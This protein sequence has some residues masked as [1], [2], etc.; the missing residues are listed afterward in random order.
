MM[1]ARI[2]RARGIDTQD[3]T[4]FPDAFSAAQIALRTFAEKRTAVNDAKRSGG[5][6]K[7]IA[8]LNTELKNSL[9]EGIRLHKLALSLTKS[10]SK[11]E[12]VFKTREVLAYL[13]YQESLVT[14][15]NER[16]LDGAILADFVA[17]HAKDI[18]PKSASNAANIAIACYGRLYNLAP[19][20]QRETEIRWVIDIARFAAET[21]PGSKVSV[22]ATN[23]LGKMFEQRRQQL[24]AAR[25][26][27]AIPSSAKGD[28]ETAQIRAGQK[29]WAHFLETSAKQP[30]RATWVREL[31]NAVGQR[32]PEAVADLMNPSWEKRR[33]IQASAPTASGS[34][35]RRSQK[36]AAQEEEKETPE[37]QAAETG[38]RSRRRVEHGCSGRTESRPRRVDQ[39]GACRLRQPQRR[40]SPQ[41]VAGD[42]EHAIAGRT[43]AV[44]RRQTQG[45]G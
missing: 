3:P 38:P 34:E 25:W 1:L 12:H 5:T 40:Q 44:V 27:A 45:N 24:I 37:K 17:R 4:N 39:Q 19:R 9:A 31:T 42:A 15:S 8:T 29:Y 20:G 32:W 22:N 36:E 10:T 28:Y 30:N 33:R 18:V 21:W 16:L 43:E 41:T 26:Y 11:P 6:A 14:G 23:N 7:K 2:K 13:Y 35:G